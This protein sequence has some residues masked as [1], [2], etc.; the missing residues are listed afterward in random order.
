MIVLIGLEIVLLSWRGVFVLFSLYFQW[1]NY[2]FSTCSELKFSSNWLDNVTI[3]LGRC[4]LIFFCF[5][6]VFISVVHYLAFVCLCEDRVCGRRS[7]ELNSFVVWGRWESVQLVDLFATCAWV[8]V[9]CW[10]CTAPVN[11]A[12][13]ALRTTGTE[14]WISYLTMKTKL[15]QTGDQEKCL[16]FYNAGG[17]WDSGSVELLLQYSNGAAENYFDEWKK[18]DKG[19]AFSFSVS[20]HLQ[21]ISP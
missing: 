21:C 1:M 19:D 4:L 10:S 7:L 2:I 15:H 20:W 3:L 9:S 18:G 16:G 11:A 17:S 8:C 14:L 13:G 5:F 12:P 6:G